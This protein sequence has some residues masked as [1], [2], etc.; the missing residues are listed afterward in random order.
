M[1][2]RW[3]CGNRDTDFLLSISGLTSAFQILKSFLSRA[4]CQRL[5]PFGRETTSAAAEY[6]KLIATV[7]REFGF[8]QK[9]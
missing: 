1:R 3:L 5:S 7:E 4:P 9:L 6:W 8:V 2:A